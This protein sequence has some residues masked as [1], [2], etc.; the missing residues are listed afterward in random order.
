MSLH[1]TQP[2]L[3]GPAF[4]TYRTDDG[5]HVRWPDAM[6]AWI[7]VAHGELQR[8]AHRYNAVV[9]YSELA[10]EVQAHTGIRTRMLLPNW[11]GK[12]LEEVALRARDGG[13]P[14]LTSLCVHQDGTIGDGYA[15]APKSVTGDAGD[16][17]EVYAAKHRLLCYSLYAT[18]LPHDGGEPR[19]TPAVAAR[20]A[21]CQT[22]A[23]SASARVCSVHN[24]AL[25]A[26]GICDSCD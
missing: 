12:L 26:T 4:G 7:P 16:D 15:Q 18:D 13:E 9:T 21:R 22:S 1:T 3:P 23:E 25:P 14:P 24:L 8:T 5:S 20:R 11:I 10:E 6:A 2:M 19:L 17:L